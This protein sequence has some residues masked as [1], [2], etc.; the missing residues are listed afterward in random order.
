MLDR[1]CT[2]TQVERCE[3]DLD[4]PRLGAGRGEGWL[5]L[6]GGAPEPATLLAARRFGRAVAFDLGPSSGDR[7]AGV[8]MI[9]ADSAAEAV[10]SWNALVAR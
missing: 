8:P 4:A 1:L 2:V 7:P 10:R 6:V 3:L 5:A 9:R